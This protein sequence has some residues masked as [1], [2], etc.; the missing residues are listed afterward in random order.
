MPALKLCVNV[1]KGEVLTSSY[2]HADAIGAKH[3][4]E[5][6]T[7]S[8]AI[9]WP[10]KKVVYFRFCCKNWDNPTEEDRQEAYN[11]A[12]KALKLL[13][14]AGHVPKKVGVLFWETGLG[15]TDWDVRI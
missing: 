15:I 9:Y 1:K 6:D 5:Y 2:S 11:T 3:Y 10:E 7:F 12:E 8:R 13:Q 14:K 4:K